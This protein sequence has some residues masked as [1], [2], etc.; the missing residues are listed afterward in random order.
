MDIKAQKIID[1]IAKSDGVVIGSSVHLLSAA[2][3]VKVFFDHCQEATISDIFDNKS[4]FSVAVTDAIGERE[5]S[6]YLLRAWSILGGSEGGRLSICAHDVAQIGDISQTIEKTVEDFYRMIRQKRTKILG[7]DY[8]AYHQGINP[9]PNVQPKPENI[10]HTIKEAVVENIEEQSFTECEEEKVEMPQIRPAAF[11]NLD[12]G[13]AKDIEELTQFFKHQLSTDI[14]QPSTE[15]KGIYT[16]PM[17]SKPVISKEKTCKQMTQN[18]PHYFQSH[19]AADF[20]A[21]FQFYIHGKQNFEGYV[22][23]ENGDCQYFEGVRSQ[24]D[25]VMNAEEEIWKDILKGKISAQKAFMTGQLKVRGNF[26]ILSKFD[27]MFKKM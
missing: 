24:P 17:G 15:K 2:G 3:A 5:V 23:I 22:Q 27:Q 12:A 19:L 14:P 10:E 21:C 9:I 16:R 26:M 6:E 18:L 11:E 8:L 7:S 25:I 20:G 1:K 13:Q 4:M